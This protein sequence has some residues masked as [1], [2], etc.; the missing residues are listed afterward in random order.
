MKEIFLT[1]NQ[2][3]FVDD[4]DFERVSQFKWRA[5]WNSSTKSFYAR[6]S[7]GIFMSRFIVNC[8]SDKTVDHKSHVTLD[9]QKHNLRICTQG[10]NN[11]NS[12]KRIN[13]SSLYK[14]VCKGKGRRKWRATIG[15]K[16]ILD[17][18]CIKH[19]GCFNTEGEAALAYNKA[20]KKHFGEFAY[21]NQIEGTE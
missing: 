20:A 15:V 7:G 8:P 18:S 13:C 14:G 17:Q 2:A 1:Q 10:E 4:E 12:R 5:S 3:A 16:D 21:L 9:N 19:L 11:Q 6:S